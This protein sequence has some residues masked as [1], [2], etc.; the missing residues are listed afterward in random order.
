[1][2]QAVERERDLMLAEMHEVLHDVLQQKLDR[3]RHP[4]DA[5]R[6]FVVRCWHETQHPVARKVAPQHHEALRLGEV[7]RG[8][9]PKAVLLGALLLDR[10]Q[11]TREQATDV[12]PVI[13][14]GKELPNDHRKDTQA[15]TQWGRCH[16]LLEFAEPLFRE[17][18]E[19]RV[20]EGEVE[21]QRHN[22]GPY[23]PR[24]SLW[25]FG[26]APARAPRGRARLGK[27]RPHLRHVQL[28]GPDLH[29]GEWLRVPLERCSE[30]GP[31]RRWR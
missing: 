31:H 9:H 20:A 16:A 23:Q 11:L 24:C 19:V 1:M 26:R 6:E 14:E 27:G 13:R 4:V 21:R 2:A 28:F 5:T 22:C 12:T 3:H 29:G 18:R 10:H 7:L 25:N 30:S 15:Q 8:G 17:D